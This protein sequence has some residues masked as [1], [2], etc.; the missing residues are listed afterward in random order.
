M[1]YERKNT[2]AEKRRSELL[3]IRTQSEL[4][5]TGNSA[6]FPSP[7]RPL[8]YKPRVA[9]T[10]VASCDKALCGAQLLYFQNRTNIG[11]GQFCGE[12]PHIARS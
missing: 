2:N 3:R 7:R 8:A 6:R 1:Y 10:K 9:A 5:N 12:F 4:L 11:G